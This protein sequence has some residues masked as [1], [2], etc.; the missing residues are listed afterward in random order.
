MTQE[1][2]A[3]QSG[4]SR[5][6]TNE[7]NTPPRRPTN[8]DDVTPEDIRDELYYG[9]DIFAARHHGVE[10][11]EVEKTVPFKPKSN[12]HHEM[13]E[14]QWQ[15]QRQTRKANH[16]RRQRKK[17]EREETRKVVKTLK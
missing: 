2:Y 10:K 7:L 4:S 15:A 13:S 17:Q 5:Q 14:S 3:S 6:I 9:W 1:Y 16:K 11:T 8:R 12:T